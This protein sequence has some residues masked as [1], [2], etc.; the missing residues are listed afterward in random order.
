MVPRLSKSSEFKALYLVIKTYWRSY[1][2]IWV[3][4]IRVMKEHEPAFY[5]L[6]LLL[7]LLLIKKSIKIY[8][9]QR[10]EKLK[11]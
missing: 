4:K 9:A 7:I 5:I 1:N 2:L 10:E 3:L 8:A 6:L 11:I